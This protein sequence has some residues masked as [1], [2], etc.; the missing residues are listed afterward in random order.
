[1]VI[2]RGQISRQ[3]EPGLG[4]KDSKEYKKVIKKTHGT[5]YKEQIKPSSKK[6]KV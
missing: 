6:S 4:S 3:L 1:M 2:S 5:I